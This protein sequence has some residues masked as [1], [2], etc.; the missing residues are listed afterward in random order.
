MHSPLVVD[1]MLRFVD[2]NF[3]AIVLAATHLFYTG[4]LVKQSLFTQ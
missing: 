1:G 3:V 4:P 2:C